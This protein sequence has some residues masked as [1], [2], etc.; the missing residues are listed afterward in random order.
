MIKLE[1]GFDGGN[2]GLYNRWFWCN[3]SSLEGNKWRPQTLYK[4]KSQID[5]DLNVKSE[6]ILE[7][8][9]RNAWETLGWGGP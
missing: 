2:C 8:K 4:N 5:E 3:F 1:F 7:E 6:I 9:L